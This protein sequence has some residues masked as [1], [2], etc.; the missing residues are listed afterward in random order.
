MSKFDNLVNDFLVEGFAT[1]KKKKKKKRVKK[2]RYERVTPPITPH[3]A[4]V[5]NLSPALRGG[6]FAGS[7]MPF[8]IGV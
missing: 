6:A 7:P 2:K 3:G 1:R 4:P 5:S 8:Q